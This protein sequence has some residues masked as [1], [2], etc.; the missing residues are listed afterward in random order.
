[1]KRIFL[2]TFFILFINFFLTAQEPVKSRK[3]LRTERQEKRVDET[4]EIILN[5]SFVFFPTQANPSGGSSIHL[6]PS[7]KVEIKND[8]VFSYLPF[9]G[10]AYSVDYGGRN[11][12]FNFDLPIKSFDIKDKKNDYRVKLKIKNNSDLI[13]YNFSISENGYATLNVT[14]TKRR[15]ISF[16]GTIEKPD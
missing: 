6:T 3:E 15:S 2:F 11:S 9:Y 1:M 8:S 14:S 4:R 13:T 5:R 12:A 10:V 7:F 16:Y